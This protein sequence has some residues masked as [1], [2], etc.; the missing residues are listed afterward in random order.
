VHPFGFEPRMGAD[1]RGQEKS[2]NLSGLLSALIRVIRGAPGQGSQRGRKRPRKEN[3]RRHPFGVEPRMGA[4]AHRFPLC[5][6]ASLLLI[7]GTFSQSSG[8]GA[9]AAD[10]H[11]SPV[12][13]I[14]SVRWV[15]P[16]TV[17]SA[18]FY[19][20]PFRPTTFGSRSALSRPPA[21][22]QAKTPTR[23]RVTA[24]NNNVAKRY[25]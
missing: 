6:F 22:V 18:V 9:H 7:P 5:V 12:P 19:R 4:D 16:N 13:S 20:S 10:A 25:S 24:N 15:F 8:T 21:F 1:G 3:H 11:V 17:G 14:H 23:F 2:W